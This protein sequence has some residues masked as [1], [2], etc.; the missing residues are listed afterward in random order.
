MQAAESQLPRP[1]DEVTPSL[2]PS[3]LL[4]LGLL[5]A[6][7]SLWIALAN[8]LPLN[9]ILGSRY[10]PLLLGLSVSLGLVAYALFRVRRVGFPARA[11]ASL[12][13]WLLVSFVIGWLLFLALVQ[14]FQR[15][16]FD[17]ALG[18][19][20]GAWALLVLITTGLGSRLTQIWRV[21]EFLTF[22]LCVGLVG[23]ELCLRG[24]AMFAPSPTTARVGAGPGELVERFRC[25]PGEVRFGYP[26]NSRGFYDEEFFRRDP[27]DSR[28][29]VAAIGDSFSV[30]MVPHSWHFTSICEEQLD[31][32]FDSIGVPGI[33]PAEY[34]TLLVEEALPLDPDLVLI[35]IFVGN[36]LN[37][38]DALVELPDPGL[39]AWLQRDQVLLFV[40]PERISRL[41]SE[42]E[43][44]ESLGRSIA[45]V[46]GEETELRPDGREQAA[47]AFPW[48][49]DPGLEEGT[50]SPDTYH[51]L[52]TERALQIC[53]Q[54]PVSL[55]LLRESLS[56]AR[57]AAGETPVRVM[58]IPDEF[59][60]EDELWEI[61]SR[62]TG[63]PLERTRAQGLLKVWLEDE[64]FEYLDLL[65]VLTGVAPL[66]DGDRHLYHKL[67]TH[68]N[69]RGNEVVAGAIA[70]FLREDLERIRELRGSQR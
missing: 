18:G 19:V 67:D 64:G 44:L 50:L 5:V 40:L 16:W 12:L 3:A 32:R 55:E 69:A 24:W 70:D 59:Q 42:A 56:A 34:L 21:A 30:G 36:D 51:G 53:S 6:L 4:L 52:E 9:L 45:S 43:R 37:V 38:Y 63:R 54:D 20:V 60:V 61:V 14:P 31:A 39:R 46:Q 7:R 68:F 13:R 29:L 66:E 10:L 8:R 26:C 23:T 27:G 15:I 33:G 47:Q 28:P 62:R 57:R 1:D 49:L 58:L 35:G 48:V 2:L 41:R 17:L 25:Q 11:R 22:S 65:P